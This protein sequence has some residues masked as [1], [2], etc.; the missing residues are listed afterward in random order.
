MPNDPSNNPYIRLPSMSRRVFLT[1]FCTKKGY[2]AKKRNDYGLFLQEKLEV[3]GR[4]FFGFTCLSFV[5]CLIFIIFH[6]SLAT[7]IRRDS[8]IC[9]ELKCI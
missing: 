2:G 6:L 3:Y 4:K 1:A 8:F 5:C 7:K 9:L